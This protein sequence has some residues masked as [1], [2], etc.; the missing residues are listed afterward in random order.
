MTKVAWLGTGLMGAPMARHLAG[1]FDLHVWNRNS[2]RAGQLADIAHVAESPAEAADGA[3]VVISM[4]LDGPVTE[5]VLAGEGAIAS[6]APGALVID[7]GSVEPACDR[8]LAAMAKDLGK[9]FVD[10][11]VSGGVVGAEAATLSIFA[12]GEKEDFEG[13]YP[14]LSRLGRPTHMGAVGTGQVAK[15]ANQLIVAITIGAVA[16]ALHFA[17]SAGCD[18]AVL[19][20]AL[21]GGFADSRILNLHGARMVERNFVPGGRSA[22]QLKDLRNALDVAAETGVTLPLGITATAGFVDLVENK[23]G[24]DLDHA[25]YYLWLKSKA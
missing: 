7:M 6:A 1:H 4:L 18:P 20:G 19:R 5:S 13:A 10:A 8:R 15:L 11:P 17:K 21:M 2:K 24:A 16:E 14:I 3:D 12:G 9:R 25:A 23:G 22:A